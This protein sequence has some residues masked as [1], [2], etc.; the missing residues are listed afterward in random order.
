[1]LHVPVIHRSHQ[2]LTYLDDYTSFQLQIESKQSTLSYRSVAIHQTPP[3]WPTLTQAFSPPSRRCMQ[4]VTHFSRTRFRGWLSR[5]SHLYTQVLPST[6][7]IIF[8]MC[9][10]APPLSFCNKD[11]IC[12]LVFD[13]LPWPPESMANPAQLRLIGVTVDRF[14]TCQSA[15]GCFWAPFSLWDMYFEVL[16]L[17]LHTLVST[18]CFLSIQQHNLDM[19]VK[20]K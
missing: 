4:L 20:N 6:F 1:M 2:R 10:S 18:T 5:C 9:F 7:Q 19:S 8:F 12:M 16:Q 11:S 14:I 15:T 17:P 13:N 3:T